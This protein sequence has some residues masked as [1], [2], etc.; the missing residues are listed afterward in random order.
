M[1]SE[2]WSQ[3]QVTRFARDL[4]KKYAGALELLTPQLR[5]GLIDSF[6]VSLI[7]K[8][9]APVTP[10]EVRTL[11]LGLVEKMA[12]LMKYNRIEVR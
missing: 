3:E 2:G 4:F 8:Q 12:E 6:I 10:E 1:S 9:K 5:E 7:L 11:R